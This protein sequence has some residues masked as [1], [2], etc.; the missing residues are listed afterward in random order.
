MNE[1]RTDWDDKMHNTLWAHHTTVKTSIKS[2][3]FRFA[4]RLEAVMPIEFKVPS[5][6]VQ[7][8]ERLPKTEFKQMRF[9]LLLRLGEGWLVNLS[10]LEHG[11]CRC[12]AFDD[13]HCKGN[14]KLFETSKAFL[15]FQTGLGSMPGKLRFH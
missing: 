12:K 10:Q 11:Q 4:F 5:I 8:S 14:D 7:I 1:N 6:R 2:M 3:P 13:C 15:V 9:E